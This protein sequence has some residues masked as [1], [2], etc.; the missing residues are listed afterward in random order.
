MSCGSQGR[1]SGAQTS[2]R[3]TGVGAG[4]LGRGRLCPSEVQQPLLQG[5]SSG[6]PAVCPPLSWELGTGSGEEPCRGREHACGGPGKAG[7]VAESQERLSRAG[8][9]SGAPHSR[10]GVGVGWRGMEGG[11]GERRVSRG[12]VSS[13]PPPGSPGSVP[14]WGGSQ[15]GPSEGLLVFSRAGQDRAVPTW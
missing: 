13:P 14:L 1:P 9:D 5:R 6:T 11:C 4:P 2:P 7:G 3:R 8:A 12:P 10:G 15:R